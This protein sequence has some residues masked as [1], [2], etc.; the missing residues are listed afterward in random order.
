MNEDA[1]KEKIRN[2]YF[3]PDGKVDEQIAWEILKHTRSKA[4]SFLGIEKADRHNPIGQI[5]KLKQEIKGKFHS[6]ESPMWSMFHTVQYVAQTSPVKREE[7]A[8]KL[9]GNQSYQEI[10]E[11]YSTFPKAVE[12]KHEQLKN[13]RLNEKIYLPADFK[14]YWKN[15]LYDNVPFDIVIDIDGDEVIAEKQGISKEQVEEQLENG[16]LSRE[17]IIRA[18]HEEACKIKD[19]FD[20]YDVPYGIKFSGGKGFH[21]V[22]P[23]DKIKDYVETHDFR[24][25]SVDFADWIQEETGATFDDGIYTDKRIFRTPYSIH[26]GTGYVVLPLTDK[27]FKNFQPKIANPGYV[28]GKCTIRDRGMAYRSGDAKD[29]IQDF[30]EWRNKTVPQK[31]EKP[32]KMPVRQDK[33]DKVAELLEELTEQEKKQLERRGVL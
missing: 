27:Q 22:I 10:A 5:G 14:N 8:E 6:A 31:Q 30:Q 26:T 4:N 23:R 33:V 12:K 32:K 17:D 18:S 13:R 15:Y 9:E 24:T 25:F 28:K 11:D 21:F 1:I 2:W 3:D 20:S 7:F 16:E 19:F 29:L